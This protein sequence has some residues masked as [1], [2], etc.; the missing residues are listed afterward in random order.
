MKN[1]S[2]TYAGILVA[3][4]GTLLIQAGF[5][6]ACT[7]EI[8]DKVPLLIGGIM[9]AIGRYRVGGITLAGTRK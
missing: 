4:G 3:V 6:E 7:N 1:F 5:T 8:V 9:A 2:L